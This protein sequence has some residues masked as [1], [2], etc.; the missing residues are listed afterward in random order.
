MNRQELSLLSIRSN[1]KNYLIH[2]LYGMGII[3]TSIIMLLCTKPSVSPFGTADIELIKTILAAISASV[4]AAAIFTYINITVP[5]N[6][7]KKDI[8]FILLHIISFIVETKTP[9]SW[10]KN[11]IFCDIKSCSKELLPNFTV[12]IEN[13]TLPELQLKWTLQHASE[14]LY[15][16]ESVTPTVFLLS[17]THAIYWLSMMNSIKRLTDVHDNCI[18]TDEKSIQ[19]AKEE[20]YLYMEE[21]LIALTHFLETR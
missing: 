13:K 21:Y 20:F 16:Y 1:Q 5:Q 8:N 17:T 10:S 15:L 11:I 6:K 12:L 3:A 2:F 18:W 4:I 19:G 7:L 9:F 14:A